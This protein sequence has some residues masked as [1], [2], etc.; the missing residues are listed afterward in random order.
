MEVLKKERRNVLSIQQNAVV[1]PPVKG[2]E[3]RDEAFE[4][5]HTR[6]F[7]IPHA[8]ELTVFPFVEDRGRGFGRVRTV[9]RRLLAPVRHRDE[10]LCAP[11]RERPGAVEVF[12]KGRTLHVA[13]RSFV[14]DR[15]ILPNIVL[16]QPALRP[17]VDLLVE[18][19]ELSVNGR[20]DSYCA[21]VAAPH[22][23]RL[24]FLS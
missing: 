3:S 17:T 23:V 7:V 4:C 13:S 20:T 11:S 14:L 6:H 19:G 1:R 15:Q 8:V 22:D 2:E 18:V 12:E 5:L 21:I 16:E 24:F 9:V 10:E